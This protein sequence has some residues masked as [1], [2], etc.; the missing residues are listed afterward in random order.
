[1]T[2]TYRSWGK[3]KKQPTAQPS[4]Q[5]SFI[6]PDGI[7]HY[8]PII[9]GT[10]INAEGWLSRERDY[11]ERCAVSGERW[12]PPKERAAEKKAEVLKL[13]DYG[14]SVI[15]QRTLK[16][17]TRIEYESKWSQLIEPKLGKFAVSDLTPATVRKWFSDLGDEHPTRN[18]HAYAILNTICNTA[19]RD[20]LLDRN[21]CDVRGAM[22]PK[23]KKVVKIPTTVELHGIADKLG[24]DERTARFRA[25]VLLAGWCGMRFGEV[26]EL[27]RKDFDADCTVVTISR[28]VTHR[29][30]PNTPDDDRCRIDTTK[31]A[32][33]R[34]VTIP[35]HIREDVKNHLA[36]QVGKNPDSLLFTPAQGGCHL[37]DR[38]FNK[39][40][41]KKAA[42]NLGREDLSAHDLRRFA[43]SKNAQ[44]GTL[45]ENMARLGHKTVDAALRY[46]HSQDG[47]DAVVAA[48]LS[49]NALA[50][51]AATP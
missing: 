41:F 50:E 5:A 22:N 16:P 43:G 46:Q 38:V 8:A 32:E 21:P 36:T 29:A 48:N 20:G 6:G 1:M 45:T 39:D 35:P 31:N 42:E 26:S 47:R 28:A 3:I 40:V 17:R 13:T 11:K 33:S 37:N 34:T 30:D 14:K 18:G 7:R 15:D 19:V 24:A 10:K 4:F 12:K 9:F 2:K 27:R 49:A 23:T 25:L 51:L 44:V